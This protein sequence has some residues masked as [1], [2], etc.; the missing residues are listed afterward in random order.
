MADIFRHPIAAIQGENSSPNAGPLASVEQAKSNPGLINA[1][2]AESHVDPRWVYVGDAIDGAR[3]NKSYPYQLLIVEKVR[4]SYVRRFSFTLPIPPQEMNI[5]TPFAINTSVTLGGVVEEHNGAP[6]RT[7]VFSGT[8]GVYP[9]RESSEG[10]HQYNLARGIYAGT[11]TN[12][13][14]V[15]ENSKTLVGLKPRMSIMEPTP[16]DLRGTG[17]FQFRLLQQ[18]LESYVRMKANGQ[19]TLRLA[20]AIW[21]DEAVYLVTPLE[22]GVRRSSASP[23][24]YPYTMSFKAW[25]RIKLDAQEPPTEAFTPVGRDPTAFTQLLNKLEA[26]RRVLHSAREVMEAA[27]A[28]TERLL[29]APLREVS[30]FCKDLMSIPITAAELPGDIARSLKKASVQASSIRGVFEAGAALVGEAA[31][32]TAESFHDLQA[33]GDESEKSNSQDGDT[34]NSGQALESAAPPNKDYENPQYPLMSAIRPDRLKLSPEIQARIARER[35]R[36]RGTT[37]KDFEVLRDQIEEFSNRFADAVGAGGDVYNDTV[38]RAPAAQVRNAT[39]EDYRILFNLNQV[40]MEMNRLAASGSIE[41]R[42]P[43]TVDSIAGMARAAGIAFTTPTSKFAV[44]FTYG[45]TLEQLSLQYLGSPD[46][47]HEIAALNGLRAPYVDEVGFTTPLLSNGSENAV[48]VASAKNFFIGQ[49]VTLSSTNTT[50]T[51]RRIVDIS[52]TDP[53]GSPSVMLTL[54]G[55]PDLDRYTT[56]AQSLVHAYLPDTVNSQQLI[57]VPSTDE[58]DS[59]DWMVKSIPGLDEFDPYLRVGGMDLLLTQAGDIVLTPDGDAKLATG[60]TN[61]IQRIRLAIGTPR[62]S[63][64]HHP[65]FGLGLIPGVSSADVDAN[66]MLRSLQAML[67]T[68]PA[69]AGVSGITVHKLGPSIRISMA[70]GVT[71]ANQ[72]IPLTIDIT[73]R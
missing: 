2:N 21:K 61:I 44:P 59:S 43:S 32:E 37:R 4:G 14:H 6:L 17:Y 67:A 20:V 48:T 35:E 19:G 42:P 50:R 12:A 15:V 57:Y 11:V 51:R 24:E 18:F 16:N 31:Q 54:D 8:T 5:S 7:I 46:R 26:A 63:L 71:G 39:P 34:E 47:W 49:Y 52:V 33:L 28:E 62:G 36:V 22:F 64:L 56:L 68:D 40:V 45:T 29:L 38:G 73:R 1:A 23:Y 30:L 58:P 27:A 41:R 53:L 66:D 72:T 25:G 9:L 70:V 13:L 55:D 69:F 3:W 60:L 65:D 10:L